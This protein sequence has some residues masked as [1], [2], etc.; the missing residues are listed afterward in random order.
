MTPR[1]LRYSAGNENS[2]TDPWGRSELV[3]QPDGR[4]RLDHHFSRGRGTRVWTGR[5]DAATLA[6][7]WA[8]LARSGFPAAPRP[9]LVPDA[10]VR[11]LTVEAGPVPRQVILE[12]SQAQSL[13]GYGEA[14]GLL[15]QVI[16]QLTG[17]AAPR[18]RKVLIA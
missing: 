6:A 10:T 18:S 3:I 4:T 12:Y 7:L 5:V 11:Q 13:P 2:P 17:G 1:T 16:G 9:Q 15:D 8:A 14:F